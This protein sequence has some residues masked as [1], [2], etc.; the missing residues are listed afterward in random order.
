V[1]LNAPKS[2]DFFSIYG[3]HLLHLDATS[4]IDGLWWKG[5]ILPL[6]IRVSRSHTPP[7]SYIESLSFFILCWV[8]HLHLQVFHS[9]SWLA[10][11]LGFC[12]ILQMTIENAQRLEFG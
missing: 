10:I 1:S 3:S 4:T 7:F 6:K 12:K 8:H 11:A 2:L 9:S 5:Q